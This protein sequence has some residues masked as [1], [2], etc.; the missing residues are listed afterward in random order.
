MWG[1]ST[2]GAPPASTARRAA[3]SSS[4]P[5][6]PGGFVRLSRW[7]CASASPPAGGAVIALRRL[8]SIVWPRVPRRRARRG[9]R[10]DR[11]WH[12]GHHQHDPVAR[13]GDLLV[14]DSEEV[15][16]TEKRLF[17]LRA[18]PRTK[19]DEAMLRVL[20]RRPVCWCA[21]GQVSWLSDRPTPRAFPASRPVALRGF[22]PR[23]Q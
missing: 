10:L 13:G 4:R 20:P 21:P 16:E 9:D 6:L 23:L 5:R 18:P 17:P 12:A 19:T 15:S 2:R 11:E 7:R 14:D 8:R 22:R 1:R 3:S